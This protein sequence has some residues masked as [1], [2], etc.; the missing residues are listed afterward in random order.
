MLLLVTLYIEKTSQKVKTDDILKACAK[1]LYFALVLQPCT[2]VLT[3]QSCCMRMYS[4][5]ANQKHVI[6]SCTLL[7]KLFICNT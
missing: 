5:S 6:L 1:Y 2:C 3:L 4:F 7:I